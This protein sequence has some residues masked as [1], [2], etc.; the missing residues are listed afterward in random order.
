MPSQ[1]EIEELID[2]MRDDIT[3]W[4]AVRDDAQDRINKLLDARNNLMQT[5]ITTEG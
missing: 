2:R 1:K 4:Q 3:H 5:Y